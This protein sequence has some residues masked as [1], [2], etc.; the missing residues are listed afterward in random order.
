MT[1]SNGLVI[2]RLSQEN[3]Q[4]KDEISKINS[5]LSKNKWKTSAELF[6]EGWS[7]LLG[8]SFGKVLSVLVNNKDY[9]LTHYKQISHHGTKNL[10][11]ITSLLTADVINQN[12]TGY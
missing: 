11:A 6:F 4:L 10:D 5:L 12:V 9:H 2:K 8:C 1:D 3:A 7:K